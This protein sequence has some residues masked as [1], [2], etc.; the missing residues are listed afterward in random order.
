[1]AVIRA[2]APHV[3]D[4][5]RGSVMW[6]TAAGGAVA[7]AA[8]VA[9]A[10]AVLLRSD[11]RAE[12]PPAGARAGAA[13]DSGAPAAGTVG[14]PAARRPPGA[15]PTGGREPSAA[16]GA[17]YVDPETAAA[18][19]VAANPGDPRARVI[20]DSIAA[21]PQ[22]RWLTRDNTSTVRAEVAAFVGAAAA[23]GKTPIL[24]VY[25]IPNRDCSGASAGGLP[26]HDAY[27]R[28]VDQV[29]AGLA[30]RPA[31]IVLEP[32][33]LPLMSN[34]LDGSGQARVQASMAYAVRRLKGA[35]ARA[36]VYLDA[37][38]SNWLSPAEMASRLRPAGIADGADGI[39]TNVSNYRATRDEVAYAKKV[40][41][42]VG[43]ARLR[44][45]VDT[46]RN[47]NGP[48]GDE[49]CDPKGRAIGTPSTTRTGEE[50]IAAFL[51][52]K[53]PGESDGCIAGAGQFVPG[54]AYELATARR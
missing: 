30:G 22:A 9:V 21:V 4:G 52:V 1:V 39:S 34:C 50:K 20:R 2:P 17:F 15:T 44:A 12:A 8:V 18:R 31:A 25:N 47:G 49:W 10:S 19:W 14:E 5:V 54:R 35:S 41:S 3:P 48:R 45:V 16:H 46:S 32:D 28:W 29:A 33:V 40:L 13:R 26:S 6:R 23:A 43:V 7:V 37:G 27:R 11:P 24:V 42:A 51:W 36:K 38:H 53:L